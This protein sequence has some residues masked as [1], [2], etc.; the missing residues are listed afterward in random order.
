MSTRQKM[1]RCKACGR[2]TLHIQ[3]RPTHLLH[4][5]LAVLTFG[6]WVIPWSW[7]TL[8]AGPPECTECGRKVG[9]LQIRR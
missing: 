5:F 4:L 8:A 6:L 9:L 1:I 7:I 3:N 2:K